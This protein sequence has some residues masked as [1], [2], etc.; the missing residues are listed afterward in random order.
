MYPQQN[1]SSLDVSL[2]KKTHQKKA[3]TRNITT[4]IINGGNTKMFIKNTQFNEAA[5][6]AVAHYLSSPMPYFL[7]T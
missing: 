6:A 5:A 1:K 4:V 3:S 7:T 2:S